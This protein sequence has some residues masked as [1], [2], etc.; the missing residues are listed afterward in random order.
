MAYLSIPF[1]ARS[2][3]LSLSLSRSHTYTCNTHPYTYTQTQTHTHTHTTLFNNK[4]SPPLSPMHLSSS[5]PTPPL[6]S[7]FCSWL[8]ASLISLSITCLKHSLPSLLIYIYISPSQ[9][10]PYPTKLVFLIQ[11]FSDK[12][13]SSTSLSLY[14][15]FVY[16]FFLTPPLNNNVQQKIPFEAVRCFQEYH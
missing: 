16:Y 5:L 12:S 11:T 7:S 15:S 10:L 13:L 3:S 9:L 8:L 14:L 2:L 4:H 6:F 1:I